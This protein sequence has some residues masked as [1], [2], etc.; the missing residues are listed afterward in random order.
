[1]TPGKP[2]TVSIVEDPA[3]RHRFQVDVTAT[4]LK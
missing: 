3:S 4:K 1:L 2:T